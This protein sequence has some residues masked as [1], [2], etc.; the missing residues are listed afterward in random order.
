MP[1]CET[2]TLVPVRRKHSE[3]P[4][5]R[6]KVRAGKAAEPMPKN[7]RCD[8]RAGREHLQRRKQIYRTRC[9]PLNLERIRQFSLTLRASFLGRRFFILGNRFLDAEHRIALAA[10]DGLQAVAERSN[11]MGNVDQRER[12][13]AAHFQPLARSQGFEGFARLERGKGTFQSRQI[14]FGDSHGLDLAKRWPHVNRG[15]PRTRP[16]FR[17]GGQNGASGACEVRSPHA[18]RRL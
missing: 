3:E 12:V 18:T 14:Q 1:H 4:K 10:L 16:I 9:D 13:G 6:G 5:V 15:F 7:L 17:K 11:Q 8:A 2:L